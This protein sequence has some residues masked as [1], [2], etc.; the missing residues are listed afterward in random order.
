MNNLKIKVQKLNQEAIIPK[1]A[2][3]TDSGFD[4]FTCD[5]VTIQSKQKAIIPTGLKFELPFG[6]GIQVKNKS[7]ITINGVPTT[8]AGIHADI[9]VYEG[10]ID[11]MYRGEIG[12]MIKNETN[13]AITI[14]KHTKI[15]QGVLRRV[16]NCDFIEVEN[17]SEDTERGTGGYGSSGTTL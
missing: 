16:Y 7:G 14:P 13:S 5:R 4:F 1:F 10:T 15:A 17:I 3:S 9:T 6:W 8:T 11:M 2:H 12:I